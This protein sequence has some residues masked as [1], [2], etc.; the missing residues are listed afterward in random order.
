M[1]DLPTVSITGIGACTPWGE[2]AAATG[3]AGLLPED[4]DTAALR[5]D[6]GGTAGDDD[7]GTRYRDRASDLALR[8]A[9]PALRDAGLAGLLLDDRDEEFA[10]AV[11]TVVSTGYGALENVCAAV[12]TIDRHSS[13][14][15]S[16]MTAHAM[17]SHVVGSWVTIRYGLR[18]PCL[19]LCD[20]PPSGIDALHWAR[21]LI[22]MRRAR[23]AL[24][25]GVEPDTAPVA[26]LLGDAAPRFDG[27]AAL[28]L[29]PRDAA[30]ARGA[31]PYAD[32]GG[33]ARRPDPAEAAA[34]ALDTP[35]DLWLPPEAPT[36]SPAPTTTPEAA[37]GAGGG[38][39]ARSVD[40]AVRLGRSAGALGV[41]QCAVAGLLIDGG[42]ARSALACCGGAAD[43]G[44][45]D[46][47]AAA[48]ALLAPPGPVPG[49]AHAIATTEGREPP[50]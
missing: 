28:I 22:V 4:L 16:P 30:L 7:R 43:E 32:L 15:L 25:I 44:A 19:T 45:A 33:Y 41:L 21:N 18:G 34:A 5:P 42:A 39:A 35:A 1:T 46:G 40:L 47:G 6:P 36:R 48:L 8:A 23:A 2:G 10:E 12:D 50:P 49:R 27:A 29:E 17:S 26:R 14:A 3:L 20:G 9:G 38:E 13:A 31:R 37:F 11:A 24:V